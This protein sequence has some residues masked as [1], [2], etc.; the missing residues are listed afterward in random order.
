MKIEGRSKKG[1]YKRH[2]GEDRRQ[3]IDNTREKIE[4]RREKTEG[5][6]WKAGGAPDM[7][8]GKEATRWRRPKP[9]SSITSAGGVCLI[10][11]CTTATACTTATGST[12]L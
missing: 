11:L 1:K 4:G 12:G 8:T 3:K 5:R 7:E 9:R 10:A 6:G 2:K